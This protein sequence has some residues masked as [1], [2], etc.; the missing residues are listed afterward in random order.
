MLLMLSAYGI[1]SGMGTARAE[2]KTI[3]DI[4][5][6]L[7]ETIWEIPLPFIIIIGIYG[8][9][10]VVGEAAAV[11]ALYVIVVEVFIYRDVKLSQLPEIMGRSMM[12]FGGILII[13]AASM[14]STN[15]FDRPADTIEI[16]RVL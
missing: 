4:R 8:G 15:Y 9:F 1:K 7:R 6:R 13:L 12:L 10:L 2:K 16:I 11:T 5:A 14:A 3:S